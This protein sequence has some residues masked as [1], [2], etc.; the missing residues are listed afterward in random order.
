MKNIF[1][2]FLFVTIIIVSLLASASLVLADSG[3]EI[4]GEDSEVQMYT[5]DFYD[6]DNN[7]IESKTFP[8]GSLIVPPEMPET[9]EKVWINT[10]DESDILTETSTAS[11]DACYYLV[12]LEEVV[13]EENEVVENATTFALTPDSVKVFTYN[14][15]DYYDTEAT[16]TYTAGD[17]ITA[18]WYESDGVLGFVGSGNMYNW[19]YDTITR[20]DTTPWYSIKSNIT[21]VYFSDE[22]TTIGNYA[23]EGCTSLALIGSLPSGLTEI[24]S[25]AFDNC[26]NL[27][28]TGE[29]PSGL[30]SIGRTAFYRCKNLAL[31][32]ELP[33][34]LITIDNFAFSSCTNLVLS[35]E[36]PSGL[37]KIGIE[38]FSN[39]PYLALTGEL[40]SGLTAIENNTFCGCTNLALTGSLPSGLTSIGSSAFFGCTNLALTGELPSGLT[41]IGDYAFHKC[42][43]LALTGS[44]PSGLTSIGS[45][46]FS[47]CENLALTGELPSGLTS[48][49]NSAFDGC[50]SLAL[51]GDIPAGVTLGA[52][53]F[54]GVNPEKCHFDKDLSGKVSLVYDSYSPIPTSYSIVDKDNNGNVIKTTTKYGY[55]GT[56]S[57]VGTAPTYEGYALK[58]DCT[59]AAIT[60]GATDTDR[61]SLTRMYEK[62]PTKIFTYKGKDYYDTDATTVYEA[63]ADIKA[64]WYE[65]DGVLGFVGTGD[66]YDWHESEYSTIT[67]PWYSIKRNITDVYFSD[68]ITSIGNSAF[69]G[70]TYL[71]SINALPSSLT[72][73]GSI[74]FGNCIG[75]ALSGELPSSL[76][77]IGGGAFQS[78]YNLALTG[79][80][81]SGLTSIGGSVF[82]NCRNLALTG[83][84][85]SSLTFIGSYT[86]KDCFDLALSGELP[87]GLTS[88]GPYAFC[89]CNN[90]ALSGELPSG[91]T[92]IGDYTFCNCWKLAITGSFPTG[93]TE[94]GD[95]AFADCTNLALTGELPSGLTKISG[96]AFHNC[97]NLALSGELPSDLTS[98]GV[99]T[100]CGCSN[101]ALIGSL[102][103][104]LTEIGDA[105]FYGCLKSCFEA[106]LSNVTIIKE[107]YIPTRFI[108]EDRLETKTD[109]LL[110]SKDLVGYVGEKYNAQLSNKTYEGYALI[111]DSD[112]ASITI[113][114][115]GNHTVL[116]RLWE[117][118]RFTVIF[119][120]NND[121]ILSTQTVDKGQMPNI[122]EA[123]EIAGKNFLRWVTKEGEVLPEASTGVCKNFTFY[124]EYT[125]NTSDY[126]VYIY[127]GSYGQPINKKLLKTLNF[128]EPTEIMLD[129]YFEDSEPF[130]DGTYVRGYWNWTPYGEPLHKQNYEELH[131]GDKLM[132]NGPVELIVVYTNKRIDIKYLN[133][134]DSLIWYYRAGQTS[135]LI[136]PETPQHSESPDKY[137]FD[138]WVDEY[139]NKYYPGKSELDYVNDS[140]TLKAVYTPNKYNVTFRDYDNSIFFSS[141]IAYGEKFEVPEPKREGYTFTG[142]SPVF[143][144]ICNGKAEYTAQYKKNPIM[145]T[146]RFVDYNDNLITSHIYKEGGS[147]TIPASPTRDGYRFTGWTPSVN[148]KAVASVTYKA[149]YEKKEVITPT[150]TVPTTP[151]TPVTP[152]PTPPTPTEPTPVP[153]PEEEVAEPDDRISESDLPVKT[154]ERVPETVPEKLPELNIEDVPVP[155]PADIKEKAP[156]QPVKQA[157]KEKQPLDNIPK[158]S[159]LEEIATPIIRGVAITTLATGAIGVGLA[160]TGGLSY[161]WL[162]LGCLLFKKKYPKILGI[163]P[164]SKRYVSHNNRPIKKKDIAM[165]YESFEDMAG[166]YSLAEAV[167]RMN[168]Q[169][170]YSVIEKSLQ[171]IEIIADDKL[172]TIE[173]SEFENLDKILCD[174]INFNKVEVRFVYDDAEY[175]AVFI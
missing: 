3:S 96:V 175:S 149:T 51:T 94:I 50:I 172:F 58:T 39:C 124:P 76:T 68:E 10:E 25:S 40:P 107:M 103:S 49:G 125:V 95:S 158:K 134:D 85:P 122:P 67:T 138:H 65:S 150:P 22:I 82:A 12:Y 18:Y 111:N 142:W 174:Y 83:E 100:F 31:T 69:S 43:N 130:D 66:M 118:A 44:L 92:F 17:N 71:E 88:I 140:R 53:V 89:N 64:Y 117:E 147:I 137:T 133:D 159:P 146:I 148:N 152:V 63:G 42:A 46:A 6:I 151:S 141:D 60:I 169:N 84:L 144:G 145:Y 80:L 153:K 7:L 110:G 135:R 38:A 33:A 155:K 163:I 81:P 154:P 73:I 16:T 109:T 105:A 115:D 56:T 61:L 90:L 171:R 45:S 37:T 79:E 21:D 108:I 78:C 86:F 48:I 13:T 87:S 91:L 27:A 116:T 119:K 121:V 113:D 131:I 20:T 173:K 136:Y 127:D 143:S 75:L 156:A 24:G 9:P 70:C 98:I 160:T 36:L 101:L 104:G 26:T 35:G 161:W 77:S 164:N 15:K 106:N 166:R 126:T 19:K 170:C 120:D 99:H 123:P 162:L 11:K 74:A 28:L 54:R 62:L 165:Y 167:D 41:S 8:E 2:H 47:S 102:P 32:G 14:G 52:G 93:L 5:I 29:L 4:S 59:D 114:T 132:V 128:D 139:G 34:N 97:K 112:E 129:N 30:T 57:S 55:V 1:K 72:T 157:T 168:A 23:F